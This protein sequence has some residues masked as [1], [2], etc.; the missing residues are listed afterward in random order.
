M[1]LESLNY[2][3][4]TQNQKLHQAV[5]T[6]WFRKK[7]PKQFVFILP[8]AIWPKLYGLYYMGHIILAIYMTIL[9]T[10]FV[11]IL[12]S[13]PRL[14]RSMIFEFRLVELLR[15]LKRRFEPDFKPI[16]K[17]KRGFWAEPK[18]NRALFFQK[19]RHRPKN[20]K[21][22]IQCSQQIYILSLIRYKKDIRP[23]LKIVTKNLNPHAVEI[24]NF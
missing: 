17:I 20:I 2:D 12:F 5:V 21:N 10:I 11:L 3:H 23:Y 6:V 16:E 13:K 22:L 15:L 14:L 8:L 9:G 4:S 7:S 19:I 18:N 1:A 24:W